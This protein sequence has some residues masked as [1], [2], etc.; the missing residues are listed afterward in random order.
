MEH[1]LIRLTRRL[2]LTRR[3]RL[4][5]TRW[6]PPA[7][8][9]ETP[10]GWLLKLEMAGVAPETISV[11]V[12]GR[13][14]TVQGQRRDTLLTEGHT[15]YS[16]EIVYCTFKRTFELPTDLERAHVSSEYDLGMLLVTITPETTQP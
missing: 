7:D 12:F 15:C 2:A 11:Q 14:I 3:D 9:Y 5:P 6:L 10:N 16:M 13:W 8:L 1:E 4:L